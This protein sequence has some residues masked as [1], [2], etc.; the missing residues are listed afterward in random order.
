MLE[1]MLFVEQVAGLLYLW[2]SAMEVYVSDRG[3][4]SKCEMN[5]ARHPEYK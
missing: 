5:R 2:I 4:T 3:R 1:T